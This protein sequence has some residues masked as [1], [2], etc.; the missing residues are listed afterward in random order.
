M[1]SS[2]YL[3]LLIASLLASNIHSFQSLPD[4]TLHHSNPIAF[5]YFLDS[6]SYSSSNTKDSDSCH[7]V[8]ATKEAIISETSDYN[9]NFKLQSFFYKFAVS[10]LVL[11]FLPTLSAYAD[12]EQI[13]ITNPIKE[14]RYFSSSSSSSFY[15]Y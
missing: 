12:S 13:E 14:V 11:F 4:F 6:Q 1:T 2:T 10:S 8:S 7:K 3:F 9:S 5:P 15:F